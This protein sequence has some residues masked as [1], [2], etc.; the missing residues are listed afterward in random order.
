MQIPAERVVASSPRL[1][2]GAA[3]NTIQW[4]HGPLLEITYKN[5]HHELKCH[6]NNHCSN[7]QAKHHLSSNIDHRANPV[8]TGP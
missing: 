5:N 3:L 4:N 6:H 2:P 8:Q 1:M 7:N